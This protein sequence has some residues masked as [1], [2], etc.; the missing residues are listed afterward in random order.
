V[1]PKRIDIWNSMAA[2]IAK[3]IKER[4]L[5]MGQGVFLTLVCI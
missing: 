1:A 4:H 2:A 3:W 5:N